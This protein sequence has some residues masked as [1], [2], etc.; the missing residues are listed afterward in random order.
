[1]LELHNVELSRVSAIACD[2]SSNAKRNGWFSEVLQEQLH[3]LR[4]HADH[5]DALEI[6]DVFMQHV[7]N[8]TLY[9][10]FN[11]SVVPLTIYPALQMY[12]S[13]RNLSQASHSLFA[14][15]R[16]L[17]AELPIISP[18]R[19]S[20]HPSKIRADNYYP[21]L[22]LLQTL[23][24][25]GPRTLLMSAIDRKS[26]FQLKPGFDVKSLG[27]P[28]SMCSVADHLA[29]KP[30]TLSHVASLPGMSAERAPRL[31]NALFVSGALNS[32]ERSTEA[33]ALIKRLMNL[34]D[35]AVERLCAM[36]D[37]WLGQRSAK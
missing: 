10:E 26:S 30:I 22:P 24:L 20:A 5:D 6:F 4:K 1:M 27:L 32:F 11:E 3:Q 15:M 36:V 16:F 28:S 19:H 25:H 23:A 34:R 8:T 14:S 13:P 18:P 2:G 7:E 37:A 17:Q 29:A 35:S 9:L 12:H 33:E 31:I 21:L